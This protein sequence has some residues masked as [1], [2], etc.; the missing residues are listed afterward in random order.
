MLSDSKRCLLYVGAGVAAY[1]WLRRRSSSSHLPS[2]DFDTFLKTPAPARKTNK[3]SATSFAAFLHVQPEEPCS[4]DFASFL[5]DRSSGAQQGAQQTANNSTLAEQ[6][7]L[8]A[9]PVTV[10][11]GTEYGF[12]R[13]IA[14]K[15]CQQLKDT[16]KFW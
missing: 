6:I 11:Y 16:G 4:T 9:V 5:K 1:L 7:P 14:E 3:A 15:L 8:D 12:A 10:I 13:E 2:T